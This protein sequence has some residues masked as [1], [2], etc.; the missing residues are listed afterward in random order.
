MKWIE[1]FKIQYRAYRYATKADVGGIAYIKAKLKK[2]QTVLDVGA[3]KAG[4]LYFIQK[5]VGHEGKV[6]AFEPQSRLFRYVDHMKKLFHWHQ[7][8][9]EHLAL[10]DTAGKVTLYIPS[11]KKSKLTSPGAT[12]VEHKQ[13]LDFMTTEE[14]MTDTLDAYSQRRSICPD[15]MKIDVEGNELR[16]F[17]GGLATL[18]KCKP[19]IIVEIEARHIGQQQV[20]ETIEYLTALG[21]Q[22]FFISGKKLIP[23]ADFRFDIHQNTDNMKAYCNNFVFE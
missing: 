12:L 21:Y 3:H 13:G 4:Y 16:I 18:K 8:T 1:R 9:V 11:N 22:G 23:V 6:F 2:G 17:Q 19:K 15:F 20:L 7:V 14:V 10:S 5:L